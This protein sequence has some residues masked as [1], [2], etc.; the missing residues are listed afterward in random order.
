[1]PSYD[2]SPRLSPKE[3][4]LPHVPIESLYQLTRLRA[5]RSHD[6]VQERKPTPG[7]TGDDTVNDFISRGMISIEDAE[8]LFTLFLDRIDHFIYRIGMNKYRDLDTVRRSSTILTV[9][10]C[11]VAALHDPHS[12]HLYKACSRE[13]YRL[14]SASM[15]DRHIDRDR[16]RAL[17][18]ASFWLH[19]VS[20][21]SLKEDQYEIEPK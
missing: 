8:R 11:T 6:P 20:W 3:D 21:V 12:N 15:F 5:L 16:M 1:M 9:T 17:C 18:V 7:F 4:V 14:M 10:I 2:N 13:F 19:D